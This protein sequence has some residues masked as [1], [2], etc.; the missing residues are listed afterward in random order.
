MVSVPFVSFEKYELQMRKKFSTFYFIPFFDQKTKS[1]KN[2][3]PFL[4]EH[5]ADETVV[6]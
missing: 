2:L 5:V 1:E 3:T 6:I 4:G